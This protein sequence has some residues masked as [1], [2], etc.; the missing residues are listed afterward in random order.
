MLYGEVLNVF[1]IGPPFDPSA[2]YSLFWFNP[3]WAGPNAMGR[4]FRFGAK[5]DL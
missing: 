4:Y 1:D 3:A 2:A 5:F